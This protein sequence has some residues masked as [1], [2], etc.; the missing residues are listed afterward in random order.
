LFLSHT[1]ES[2]RLLSL[3][4][5]APG[6]PLLSVEEQPG[7]WTHYTVREL[8]GRVAAP[9]RFALDRGWE[10]GR[11]T[12]VALANGEGLIRAVLASWLRGASPLILRPKAAD[13]E[14]KTLSAE[15]GR[16]FIVGFLLGERE[17]RTALRHAPLVPPERPPGDVARNDDG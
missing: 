2:G 10:P 4:R 1:S 17:L 13:L 9:A 3:A 15:Q 12:I 11:P 6:R 8:A 5:G 16:A 14:R 7:E